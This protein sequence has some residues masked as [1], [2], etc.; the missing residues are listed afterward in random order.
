MITVK[1]TTFKILYFGE[2]SITSLSLHEKKIV[3]A[4]INISEINNINSKNITPEL[5]F[6]E[7]RLSV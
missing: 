6:M 3:K 2:K 4:I 5:I 1:T 7:Q